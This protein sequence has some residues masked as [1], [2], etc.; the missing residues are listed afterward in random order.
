MSFL[1][2]RPA[3][4]RRALKG[5][6]RGG[7][8]GMALPLLDVFL[9]DNGTALAGGAPI[10][11]RFGN[12]FWGMG[13]TPGHAIGPDTSKIDFLEECKALIPYT[14][15][16]N[17]F[18]RFNAP[19]DGR[20]NIT[21]QSGWVSLKTG[22]PPPKYGDIPAPTFD[23]LIS[24]VV[25][26]ATRFRAL[27]VACTGNPKDTFSARGTYSRNP[28]EVSPLAL[29][30]R[31]FG[32][33][34]VDPNSANF[35]PDPELLLQHSVLSVVEDQRKQFAN[36]IGAADRARLDEYTTSIRQLEN[37]I[38]LQLEKPTPAD[39]CRVA[40]APGEGPIGA[41]LPIVQANHRLMTQM[42]I[43]ALACNQTR[44]FNMAFNDALSCLRRPGN[45]YT[46]HILTHEEPNHKTLGYQV[47]AFWFNCRVM[48]A[49]AEFI[50][51]FAAVREGDGYLLDN[52]LIVAHSEVSNAKLHQVDNIPVMTIGT[53]GKR[54][55][56]GKHISGNGDP[57]TRIG[58]TAMQLMGVPI[59]TWGTGSLQT[60]KIVSEILV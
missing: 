16:I 33:D 51:A 57:V 45:A 14:K 54:I 24:D 20:T 11:T 25:G 41:E 9:N 2:K 43:M 55:K 35:K 5:M 1:L 32:P 4:R 53:A 36:E 6:F 34:F 19:L 22:A 42:L 3:T 13:H 27:D 59:E 29:Y 30:T 50:D 28:P 60:S 46:H 15:H 49:L 47:E 26:G 7:A 44:V 23:V 31:L 52:T 38:S 21:H 48:E 40:K 8:I 17:Y 37:Q 56:T 18:G 58:L 10:P 12:W 39:A